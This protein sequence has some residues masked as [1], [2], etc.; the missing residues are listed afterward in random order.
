LWQRA[1]PRRAPRSD[2]DTAASFRRFAQTLQIDDDWFTANLPGWLWLIEREAL[3]RRAELSCLEIGSWQ[4]LSAVFLLHR[5]PA[6]HLTCVDTWAGGDEHR[7]GAASNREVLAR[8]EQ[9]FDANLAGFAD[10]VTKFKGSSR[11]YFNAHFVPEVLDLVYIDGSHRAEDV[12]IDAVQAFGMLKP[13]GILIFDDYLWHY[14]RRPIDNPAGAINAFL[15]MKR[16]EMQIVTLDSQVMIR[17]REH[18]TR[19]AP[20]RKTLTGETRSDTAGGTD[21]RALKSEGAA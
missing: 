9:A 5:L 10:R 4:G 17:K 1:R 2:H 20:R 14:Y 15:R 7:A 21:G 6:A 19:P 16:H 8:A 18:T 11:A 3:E 12:I 13:G